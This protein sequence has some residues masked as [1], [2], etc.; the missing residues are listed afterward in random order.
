[1][2]N[3]S[4]GVHAAVKLAIRWHVCVGCPSLC[5]ECGL[6]AIQQRGLFLLVQVLQS[7]QGLVVVSL[8]NAGLF[9]S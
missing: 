6:I 5:W 9:V 3:A 2:R 8:V 4:H 1:M 7:S